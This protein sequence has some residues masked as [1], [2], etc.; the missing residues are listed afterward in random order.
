MKSNNPKKHHCGN[1]HWHLGWKCHLSFFRNEVSFLKTYW[2]DHYRSLG[3]EPFL[4]NR[5]MGMDL[6]FAW[7]F[8][9]FLP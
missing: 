4:L 9:L 8:F 2:I 7:G 5:S 1:T 3:M 6:G